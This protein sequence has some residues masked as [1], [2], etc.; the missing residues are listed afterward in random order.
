MSIEK[1]GLSN[2][3]PFKDKTPKKIEHERILEKP[4]SIDPLTI[5][6]DLKPLAGKQTIVGEKVIKEMNGDIKKA[7][8]V[9][10]G[11]WRE[12]KM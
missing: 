6:K 7:Y 8:H 4:G 11:N 5:P 2:D 3:N 10:T 1:R 12:D 9:I